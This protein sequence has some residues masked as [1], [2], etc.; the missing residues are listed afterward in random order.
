MNLMGRGWVR[1]ALSSQARRALASSS[2]TH[3]LIVQLVPR[4]SVAP[5]ASAVV[6]I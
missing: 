6:R 1:L 4:G 5:A 3:T 2:R